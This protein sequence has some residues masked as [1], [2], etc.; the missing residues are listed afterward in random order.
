M[1]VHT[2]WRTA[3]VEPIVKPYAVVIYWHHWEFSL[4]YC[5]CAGIIKRITCS[6]WIS[7]SVFS[8]LKQTYLVNCI[9]EIAPNLLHRSLQSSNHIPPTQISVVFFPRNYSS[10]RPDTKYQV[11]F[12]RSEM[13][14]KYSCFRYSNG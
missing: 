12:K 8:L 1:L 3:T 4:Q 2:L 14:R 6:N 5:Y 11:H 10:A 7:I 9:K 13:K